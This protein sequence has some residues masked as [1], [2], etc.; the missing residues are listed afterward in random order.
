M[1]MGAHGARVNTMRA[2][3]GG[4]EK[5]SRERARRREKDGERGGHGQRTRRPAV[6]SPNAPASPPWGVK[7]CAGRIGRLGTGNAYLR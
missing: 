6:Y 1:T 7:S 2:G 4:G 5:I 3:R